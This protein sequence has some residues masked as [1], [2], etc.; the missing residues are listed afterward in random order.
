MTSP[1]K[2]LWAYA[3]APSHAFP[4]HIESPER[5]TAVL[6]ALDGAGFLHGALSRLCTRLPTDRLATDEELSMT[7]TY[8]PWL[9]Q[10]AS[11]A[12]PEAPVV[13]ADPTDPDGCTWVTSLEEAQRAAGTALSL[14]DAIFAEQTKAKAAAAGAGGPHSLAPA[15]FGVVRPPGHHATPAAPMGFCLFNNVALAVKHAMRR[16]GVAR[17]MVYDWDVVSEGLESH[18]ASSCYSMLFFTAVCG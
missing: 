18:L 5:A 3:G 16:H 14:V 12:S 10:K 4:G 6:A 9:H 13:V 2:L 1:P 17:A 11:A 7:H 15:A 8:V